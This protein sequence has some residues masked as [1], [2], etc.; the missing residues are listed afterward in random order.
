M[1]IFCA[2]AMA[3]SPAT[4]MPADPAT[5][6][7]TDPAVMPTDHDEQGE[8]IISRINAPGSRV[9]VDEPEAL[10]NRIFRAKSTEAE[11]EN[12]LP[13]EQTTEQGETEKPRPSRSSKAVGYRV[14]IFAD[15]N[16]RTAKSEARQRERALGQAFPEFGTYVYY[17]SPYWRLRVGD[18]R[19][20][21]D[22]EK[23][24]SEIRK[25]FPAYAKEVRVVRDRVNVRQ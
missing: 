13:E 9:N 21:Y 2:I 15:N 8:N 11:A 22:A 1:S 19:S 7:E 6:P 10:F 12:N 25:S 20:Q 3:L 16:S 18:F 24:A 4:A 14:Q 5:Y 23:A 17:D